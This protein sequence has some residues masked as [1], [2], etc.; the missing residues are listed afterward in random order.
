MLF[1]VPRNNSLAVLSPASS[2]AANLWVAYL[3]SWSAWNRVRTIAALAATVLFTIAF[4]F[5]S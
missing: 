1:N 3:S 2:E 4:R 5:R